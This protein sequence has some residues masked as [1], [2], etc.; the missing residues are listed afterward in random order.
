MLKLRKKGIHRM[1]PLV[2]LAGERL[3]YHLAEASGVE[4]SRSPPGRSP[5]VGRRVAA[6]GVHLPVM[7]PKKTQTSARILL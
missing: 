5:W 2:M 7:A 1:I 4:A 6:E 3:K